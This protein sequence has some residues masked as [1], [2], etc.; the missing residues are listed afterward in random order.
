MRRRFLIVFNPTAGRASRRK[1]DAVL[2][3]LRTMDPGVDVVT[4]EPAVGQRARDCVAA[5]LPEGI[6]AV[7]AAG[8]DGTIR[9]AACGLI[10]TDVPLGVVPLGTGNVLSHE[11]Q[12]PE[13]PADLARVLL[14]QATRAVAPALA[15]DEPFLLMAGVGLDGRIVAGLDHDLKNRIGKLAYARPV[16]AAWTAASDQLTLHLDGV[17]HQ[18]AW[19][20][21][22]KA[23]H[24][25]GRYILSPWSDMAASHM[26][27]LLF[28]GST[29][30]ARM[31]DGFALLTG[32]MAERAKRQGLL[33]VVACHHA[34][35]TSV[36]PAPVQLDGDAFGATP[37]TVRA[38]G[39][40]LRLIVP[41]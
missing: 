4:A 18:A 14:A 17:Q 27:A 32:R 40:K 39:Q 29:R 33:K 38:S 41:R 5:A 36:T 6:T 19:A 11:L 10:G 9:E 37:L 20:V 8:G 12:L 24:F 23:R 1:L 25:G 28:Q 22:A 16:V 26:T 30:M 13:R 21:L 15:N 31:G 35:V 2:A 34:V 3:A 7:V